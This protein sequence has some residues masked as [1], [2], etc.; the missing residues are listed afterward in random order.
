MIRAFELAIQQ[1]GDPRLRGVIWQSLLLSLLLQAAIVGVAW[2]ALQSF[3][4][5]QW[6]WVNSAVRWL[7]SAAVLVLALM[8]FPASFGI[9]ISIFMER[10]ADIVESAHYPQLGKAR[11]I[12]VW[13]AIWTGVVFLIA[14]IALNLVLLV[15]YLLALLFFGSGAVLFYALNG[16]LTARLYYEQVALRRLS[17]AEV[18]AWRRANAGVLWATG[19][20]IAFFGTIPVVNLIVPVVGTAAMVHVAQTLTPPAAVA[21]PFNPPAGPR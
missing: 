5:F 10:I 16:W 12:P 17:P 13:T 21:G 14:V 6:D 1:L 18:K 19:I 8:L 11:G 4:T 15:P 20:V 7:G 3:A 2:W 9:V